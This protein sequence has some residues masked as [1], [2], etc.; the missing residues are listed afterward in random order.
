MQAKVILIAA[1]ATAIIAAVAIGFSG[2]FGASGNF[3]VTAVR[4]NQPAGAPTVTWKVSHKDKVVKIQVSEGDEKGTKTTQFVSSDGKFNSFVT[5]GSPFVA[6][7]VGC[8]DKLSS[9]VDISAGTLA[10]SGSDY[11]FTSDGNTIA[12]IKMVDGQPRSVDFVDGDSYTITEFVPDQDI[13]VYAPNADVPCD[14]KYHFELYPEDAGAPGA[15]RHLGVEAKPTPNADTKWLKSLFGSGSFGKSEFQGFGGFDHTAEFKS[16]YKYAGFSGNLGAVAMKSG[17]RCGFSFSGT[18]DA[19]DVLIDI[20]AWTE[21]CV[22]G[23]ATCHAGFH[24]Y[25]GYFKDFVVQNIATQ[26]C[27]SIHFMGH[28]L[29][30]ATALI[31]A[32]YAKNTNV[33]GKQFDD[34][35]VHTAGSPR[36]FKGDTP[37]LG[38]CMRYVNRDDPIPSVPPA[39]LGYSHGCGDVRTCDWGS[40]VKYNSWGFPYP[41][42]GNYCLG[43]S[44]NF[45]TWFNPVFITNHLAPTYM[46]YFADS[47]N[48]FGGLWGL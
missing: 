38:S 14:S 16:T 47:A 24:T 37:S 44:G 21:S 1:L 23:K 3:R 46:D 35:R 5:G 18:N 12:T 25:F 15:R 4:A 22:G 10:V 42:V 20:A 28:S 45:G 7:H 40:S 30:G 17:S 33:L 41:S 39:S 19:A 8:T 31:F 26:D 34:V 27:T 36:P 11:I 13:E 2:L 9:G 6:L 48:K 29:G 43:E 32:A